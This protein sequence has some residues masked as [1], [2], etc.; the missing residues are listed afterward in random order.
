M[1]YDCRYISACEAAWR[2]FGFDINFRELAV[3]RLSF[4]LPNQQGVI[5]NDDDLI[6]EVVNEATVKETT[7]LAWFEAN[8]RYP[9]ARSLTYTQLPT[10]FEFKHDSREWC[11]RKSSY[12]IG[13]LYYVRLGLGELHYLRV[14]LTFTKGATCYEDIRII[15]GVVYPTF[16]DA[17]YAM[18][19]LDDD[20]EYVEGIVEASN[21]SSG[22]YLHDILLKERHRLSSKDHM[23]LNMLRLNGRRLK[24]YPPMPLPNDAIMN[25]MD[26]VLMREELN[27]DQN[28]M[29]SQHD[30]LLSSLTSEQRNIYDLVM[31]A[32]DNSTGGLFF[33][34]GFEGSEKTYI[35]NTLTSGLCSHGSTVLASMSC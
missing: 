28:L 10:Q 16:K 2:I 19:L 12:S 9:K 26:N 32:V 4:H 15:N 22:V 20:K 13:R 1:Y 33:V 14:L 17:C 5:F 34:N 8:K 31:N 7:F 24:D 21:W 35:W 27:Y 18:G 6:E 29:R 11:E 23:I 25:N 30:S 3:E